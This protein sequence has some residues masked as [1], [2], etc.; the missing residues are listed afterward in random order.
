MISTDNSSNGLELWDYG[1]AA[2]AIGLCLKGV[3]R[4]SFGSFNY[5]FSKMW[6]FRHQAGSGLGG[7]GCVVLD[8]LPQT[9]GIS[10]PLHTAFH[11]AGVGSLKI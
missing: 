3:W 1:N 9:G 6:R 2:P 11:L 10:V 8:V 5:L 4:E 7:D